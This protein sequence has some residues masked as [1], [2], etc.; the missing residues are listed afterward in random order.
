M[1]KMPKRTIR[2]SVVH[3][4]VT[5][6]QIGKIAYD[7]SPLYLFAT[8]TIRVLQSVMPVISA[9]IVK[10]IFDRLGAI[11]SGTGTTTYHFQQ[12]ILPIV[13]AFGVV[14]VISQS[15][16][17]LDTYVNEEMG[18]HL[19]LHTG[20]LLY[21]RL[22]MFQG[23]QYFE[24]P[25]FHDTFRQAS[26]QIQWT[27]TQLV[28]EASGF[29]GSCLTLISFFGVVLVFSPILSLVLII[30]TVPSFLAQLRFRRKRFDL[31]WENSPKERKAWYY[32]SILSST[33]YAKEMR[34]FN[35]GEY[36]LDRYITTTK[37]NHQNR[38][39]LNQDELRVNTG[40]NVFNAV[41][42]VGSYLYV[43]AQ[44]FTQTITL[45]DV[46][47]FIEAVRT[48]QL[49]L[50]G[51]S[52]TVVSLSE[53]ALF[54]SH[55]Q[56]LMEL[57]LE[58]AQYEPM[59][60]VPPLQHQIELRNLS[61]RYTEQAGFVLKNV[62]LTIRKG[63]SLALVGL[64]GAGKTTLVKLLARFYDPTEGA[65]LWDGIDIR[66]FKPECL[67]QHLGAVLQDFIQYELSVRENIGF[68]NIEYINDTP[69]IQSIAQQIGVDSF[70]QDL[71]QGYETILSRWLFDKDEDGTDLSG[72]QWQKIAIARTYLRNVEVLLL[73]EPTAALDAE[74][75]HDIYERFAEIAHNRATLL[76]SHRFS[77]V[78]MADR[79]AVIEDGCIQEYGTHQE[80]IAL[81]GTY[82]R[83]YGL[84]AAQYHRD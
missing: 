37:E 18:R 76:I 43:I 70:I 53:R 46:T 7:A 72:G 38:R 6:Y 9:Y 67:R 1:A 10:L 34:L 51:L 5:L 62:N 13:L 68:G 3:F 45:G 74:A 28:R 59:Q 4:F 69:H 64:N 29:I 8:I 30:A 21:R 26:Q 65:I 47:L 56:T 57:P 77:T 11:M 14:L 73:D 71:P 52:W 32:G 42:M 49:H 35:L 27:P 40:L 44:A 41:I 81:N 16:L 24:S 31:S 84:Q 25:Q 82:A 58:L 63:E 66:H 83:L 79:I 19:Q 2:E 36:I 23:M 48:V 55:Y 12:D 17:A 75:E 20:Q 80:L 50:N 39:E 61:F 60:D 78:R 15:L 33:N 54:F 22:L